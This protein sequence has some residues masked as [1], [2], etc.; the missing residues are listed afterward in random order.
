LRQLHKGDQP[1][2]LS[3]GSLLMQEDRR[4][5]IS[6]LMPTTMLLR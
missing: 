2:G 3:E 5:I 6:A 1:A 4:S